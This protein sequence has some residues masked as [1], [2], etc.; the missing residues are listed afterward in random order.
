MESFSNFLEQNKSLLKGDDYSSS[1]EQM[2]DSILVKN[3]DG[4]IKMYLAKHGKQLLMDY[5]RHRSDANPMEI[6]VE[7]QYIDGFHV[8]LNSL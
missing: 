2:H 6:G 4:Y 1:S 8:Y 7:E 3:L 5:H